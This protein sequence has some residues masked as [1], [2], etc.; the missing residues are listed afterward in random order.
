MKI[1]YWRVPLACLLFAVVCSAQT[2]T[3]SLGGQVRDASGGAIPGASITLKNTA[4]NVAVTTQTNPE[5]FYSISNLIPGNYILLATF[6]GFKTLD[7]GNIVLRVGDRVALDLSMEVGSQAESVTV[8]AETQLLRT[9]DVQ[10]GLVIDNRRIQELP[11]YNRNP[12]AFAQL[13]ANVNG[14]SEQE[15]HDNDMRVN[16]GRTGQTEYFI[17][18]VPATSGYTHN[19]VTSVPSME[20]V[21]E[22]KVITN[23]LS[24]EYG[25]LSGGA[26]VLTTRSGTN[27]FH[28]SGY[29]FLRNDKLNANDWN[30]NRNA[31]AKGVFHD[32]VFGGSL[33]GPVRIPKIYNGRDKTFFFFNYEG[34]R[35][36]AGSNNQLAGVPTS[37]E[38]L[39]DFSQSLIDNGKPVT[40]YD[41]TTAR[42]VNGVP[43]RDPFAGN[44]VPSTSFNPLSKIYLGF[45]PEP[46][47]APLPGSSHDQN[48]VGGSTSPSSNDVW[49][50]R[51]DENWK[52]NQATHFSVTRYDNKS[53]STRWLS[54]LQ[55]VSVRYSTAHTISIDHNWTVTP[56]SLL[57]FRAGLVRWVQFS[58]SQV[59]ADSS[60]WP[61]QREIF[62][63][64]GTTTTRVPTL[65]SD[66]TITSLGGGSLSNTFD[67]NYTGA[68]SYQ[69]LWG[70]HTIKTGYEHRRYY[71]NVPSGG[72]F[73]VSSQRSITSQ[74][75]PS[76]TGNSGSGFAGWLLGRANWGI[77]TQLAG[78]ASLQTYHGAYFQDDIKLSSK[79]TLN[80][81][82]RWD[83]E[84]PRTERHDR[85]LFWDRSYTW[86]WQPSAGWSWSNV[87]QT[88]GVNMPQPYWMTNGIHGRAAMMGTPEYP[89][90]T[91]WDA[92][93]RHLG[94]RI[95]LAWQPLPRTVLRVGYG[96]NWLTMTGNTWINGA[97]FDAGYG[98]FARLPQSGTND[99][100]MTF[101][102]TFDRPM[103]NN[104]GYVPYVHSTNALN[105]S[106]LGL[107]FFGAT[108]DY[109]PGWEHV[110]QLSIQRE[111]GSGRNTWVLEAAY[112]GNLG[113]DLPFWRGPGEHI[114]PNAANILGPL[115]ATLNTKV[116]N[117][118]Y[119]QLPPSSG[120]GAATR[121]FGSMF[122]RQPLFL[123]LWTISEPMG[124]SNYN[125][126]Y[127]QVEHRFGHGFGFLASYTFSKMLQD[128]GGTDIAFAQGPGQQGYPQA[129]LSLGDIY[130]IAPTDIT[131]K[132]VLNYSAELP[133]GRGK[134]LFGTPQGPA[135][136]VLDKVIGGWQVAGTTTLRTGTPIVLDCTDTYCWQWLSIQQSAR[137]RL[138]YTGQALDN[139]VS[140]HAALQGSANMTRYFNPAAVRGPVLFEIGDVPS[141][142]PNMRGP[143]FS[144][145]DFSLLKSFPIAG[146]SKRLQLR[147]EAQNILNHMNAGMP[148]SSFNNKVNFGA[149]TGQS[150]NPRR[151]MVAAK[152]YF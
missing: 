74:S 113:R 46:N 59:A 118:F 97:P 146:E 123:M 134:F 149:I 30:S 148:G 6:Q 152:L 136:K 106:L 112:N 61:M 91:L 117:P 105:Q 111:L 108:K 42:N 103:P 102:L 122:V 73:S 33:G 36:N 82:I 110:I 26:I 116:A 114:L 129:G 29:E 62:N 71:S 65:S 140:G 76:I 54:P 12:L 20:A 138:L 43:M 86:D 21:D 128:V 89:G 135:G 19:V 64:L 57:N 51:L 52:A 1:G 55:P 5:G 16:G 66:D 35:H 132:V 31:R 14:T 3:A 98:D 78:P 104:S 80:T 92:Q 67:T 131:H 50:G 11:Q 133:F 18:G 63:L 38:R 58:E 144:Q 41:P 22:F 125:S 109:G 53:S 48:F 142:I 32:N 121:S 69:K 94:P 137:T 101:P 115:G 143:G 15:G 8:T 7:R 150:G 95:G 90:R 49:T 40:I 13:T 27:A 120:V 47:R 2:G 9:E 84:P 24:A 107:E 34:N 37:L 151:I 119:G 79:L 93:P 139:H 68:V 145:W 23:G 147:F 77:G 88:A 45:Y 28:G 124:T 10:A 70:K 126:G 85:Q 39:G 44:K 60:N 100:G 17:D 25:R 87:L 127:L 96:I 72:T 75:W 56:T 83:F 141:S 4:T 81:G 130:G 99:N